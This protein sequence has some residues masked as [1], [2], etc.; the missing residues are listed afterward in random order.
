M[1]LKFY[2]HPLSSFCWKA[3]IALYEN[4]VPHEKIL[5]DLGNPEDRATFLKVWAI[6]KFPVI[7]DTAR[8]DWLVPEST[9]VIEY[10]AQHYPGWTKLI[11]DDPDLARQV[12]MRDRFFDLYVHMPMQRV[13]GDRIRPKDKRDPFG[14]AEA[15]AQ[16]K[17]ALGMIEHETGAGPWAMGESFTMA[18]CAAMPALH[19]ANRIAPLAKDFPNA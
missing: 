11:P 13:V 12:R 9:I 10:L 4:H 8:K 2:Y 6:G 3:L 7:V 14:V 16:M 1:T 19:Y 5:V 15:R 17:T 18:D